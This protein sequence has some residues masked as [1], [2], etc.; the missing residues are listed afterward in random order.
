[1]ALQHS[2]D[3]VALPTYT[4]AEL[5]HYI[6]ECASIRT[7]REEAVRRLSPHLVAKPVHWPEDPQDEV[8]ALERAR[9]IGINVPAV[10][11][12]VPC[13]DDGHF[14]IMDYID[15]PTIEQLLAMATVTAPITGGLHSGRTHSEWL[16]ALYGPVKRASPAMFTNHLNWWLTDCRPSVCEPRPD[17]TLQPAPQHILVHQDFVPRNMIVD[18][19]G[20]LWIIDW[21]HAGFYPAFMEY[22]SMDATSGLAMGWLSARTLAAWWGRT[23]WAL[24]RFIACGFSWRYSK[25]LAALRVVRQR[26]LRFRL[27][28]GPYSGSE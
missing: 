20:T 12:V 21:A 28:K 10:R 26:S 6:S 15:G 4:D 11:R 9:A 17:L 5:E 25:Q 27:A 3:E 8:L 19:Q 7:T 23:R 1:M 22:V 16:D 13:S 24:L 18:R 14:I 2:F